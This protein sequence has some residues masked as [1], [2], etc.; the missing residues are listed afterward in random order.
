[1]IYIPSPERLNFRCAHLDIKLFTITAKK[2]VDYDIV[3]INTNHYYYYYLS[4]IKTGAL[5]NDARK[6][7]T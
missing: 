2:F 1:M 6:K 3:S 4:S 7:H 5:H